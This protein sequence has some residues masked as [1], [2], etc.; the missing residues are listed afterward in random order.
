MIRS[1]KDTEMSCLEYQMRQRKAMDKCKRRDEGL[2]NRVDEERVLLGE[3]GPPELL[4]LSPPFHSCGSP[5]SVI[6]AS[7]RNTLPQ[8]CSSPHKTVWSGV[9]V[10]R[11]AALSERER[12]RGVCV[13]L[14]KLMGG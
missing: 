10:G 9:A 12:R 13:D 1:K 5:D 11:P 3:R 2:I 6:L 14:A 7:H 4:C 8:A